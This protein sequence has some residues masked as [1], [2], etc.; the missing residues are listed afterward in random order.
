MII[1]RP[2]KSR[3]AQDSPSRAGHGVVDT[4]DLSSISSP[5][6]SLL[7]P[8]PTEGVEKW[9]VAFV[10]TGTESYLELVVRVCLWGGSGGERRS[11]GEVIISN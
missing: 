1:I 8:L 6:E 3:Q 7:S 10:E 5:W 2:E 9:N 11:H 4:G